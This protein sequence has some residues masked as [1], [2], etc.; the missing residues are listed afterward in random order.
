M[1]TSMAKSHSD[2]EYM[3]VWGDTVRPRRLFIGLLIGIGA[4][5]TGLY[6]GRW[7][8]GQFIA[9]PTLIKTWSL[10][11]GLLGCVVAAVVCARLFPPARQ[12]T[13][14]SQDT[15]RIEKVVQEMKEEARGLGELSD[16][17]DMSRRELNE[18][19]L[20]PLFSG[21]GDQSSGKEAH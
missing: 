13:T 17:S 7:I 21:T 9:D 14:D 2:P 8:V 5:L 20:T 3:E 19:G 15:S 1:E 10:V 6:G 16:A 12:V 18:A 4:A 11:T